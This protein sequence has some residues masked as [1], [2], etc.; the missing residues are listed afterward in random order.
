MELNKTE[1]FK[2][3]CRIFSQRQDENRRSSL[4]SSQNIPADQRPLYK[5]EGVHIAPRTGPQ[6]NVA[7]RGI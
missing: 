5:L 1:G 6:K 4:Q 7:N 2:Q 3:Q